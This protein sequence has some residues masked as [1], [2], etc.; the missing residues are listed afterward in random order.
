M[1]INR[2]PYNLYRYANVRRL[3]SPNDK[4]YVVEMLVTL[5]KS[6][7]TIRTKITYLIIN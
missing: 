3:S 1:D 5:V 7:F 4:I 2:F 6:I